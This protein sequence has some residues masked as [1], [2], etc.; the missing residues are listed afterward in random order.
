M[1]K[2]LNY[3][4]KF[5]EIPLRDGIRWQ[6]PSIYTPELKDT[7][8]TAYMYCLNLRECIRTKELLTDFQIF[9][10][11]SRP[12]ALPHTINIFYKTFLYYFYTRIK[13]ISF[14]ED[15]VQ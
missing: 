15:F 4:E 1:I 12:E 9:N 11:V 2:V 6:L 7:K 13:I 3:D 5:E 8:I 14:F 10:D